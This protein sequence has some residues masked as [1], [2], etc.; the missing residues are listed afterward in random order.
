MKQVLQDLKRGQT[1][2]EET[3]APLARQGQL[4]IATTLSLVSAGT[5]RMLV[6]FARGGVISK[7]RQQ[8]EKVRQALQ[9]VRTDGLIATAEAIRSKLDQPMALGYCNVGRVID[10]KIDGFVV[11]DRVVSNGRHAEIVVVPKHLCAK[12]PAQVSDEEAAFTVLGAIGLQGVRLAQPTLGET[13]VVSGLGLIGLLTVQILH[14]NGC[15]VLGIDSDP[16][17]L[18]LARTF[19]ASTVDLA[20]GED[21]LAKATAFSNGR[22]VD[23]VILTLA[24]DS[25]APIS[26]AAQMCR[27][28][29]RIV[30][31][32][33]TGLKLNRADF[34]EKEISFQVSCSYGPGRYDVAYED[35][36]QDYP[37]GFVRW[38]EQRNFEAVLGLMASGRLDV[39]PLISHRFE[40]TNAQRAYDV[41][42]GAEKSLGVLLTYPSKDAPPTSTSVDLSAPKATG[43]VSLG[44]IGAGNYS[45]RVLINA[46]KASGAG[47]CSI[48]SASGVTAVH[49]GRKYGFSSAVSN[50][51]LI[52]ADPNI[53]AVCIATRHDSHATYVEQALDGG[54]HVFVEK[55]LCVT[56]AEL[57]RIGALA[58]LPGAPVLTVGFN[59]RFAP[60]VVKTKALL[61]TTNEP[62]SFVMTVN[63][64][65]IPNAHWTQDLTAGGGRIL[66]EAC[67]FIDLLRYLAA[68]PVTTMTAAGLTRAGG[69]PRTDVATLTLTFE[70]GSFGVI[71]YLSN[72][73]KSYPKERL[74]VFT[75]GKVLLLDNFRK[76]TGHGWGRFTGMSSLRQDKGQI[77]CA[78][79][80]VSAAQGQAPAPIPL[81]EI[82][83][84]SRLSIEAAELC[85]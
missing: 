2:I 23:G 55:P 16:A 53:T 18:A 11:G 3:P 37:L 64:G 54:K 76:L 71:N 56:A 62:A 46:F 84:V 75:S 48:A 38:T 63:A 43:A 20:A 68:A 72:G 39:R 52:L 45:G 41:I 24:T 9:K 57:E 29:G 26:Q 21:P 36:G 22:G 13:F 81:D 40:I 7:A 67:H 80:F 59:R 77:E 51:E 49:F 60:M 10:A 66:G 69:P 31:V 42:A 14:A 25:D 70:N 32:G 50:P 19:G 30:L 27:Q 4:R 85:D 1:I 79:A 78:R 83:E 12:I 44:V 34:Y 8:P 28:R 35:G 61:A 58:S 6:D 65:P 5:E 17:R 33:V 74:E 73:H 15:R 47:L 82:L